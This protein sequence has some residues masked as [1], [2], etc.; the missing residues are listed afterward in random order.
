MI[1]MEPHKPSKIE[2]GRLRLISVFSLVDQVV[3]RMLFYPMVRTEISNFMDHPCKSGWSPLPAGYSTLQAVFSGPVLAT[4]CSAFDWTFP[5]WLVAPLLES[6]IEHMRG[7]SPKMRAAMERRW[8]EVI[9]TDCL[10]RLPDG[11][12]L[13]QANPGLMK[14][15]WLLTISV[16]SQ[17]QD[18]ITRVAWNRHR[19]DPFPPFWAMGDDVLMSWPDG[20][21][22]LLVAQ[23]RK[24]G[25]LTKIAQRSREFAGF[26]IPSSRAQVEPLYA[27]KHKFVLAH[28]PVE[29]LEEL[30]S[31]YALLYALSERRPLWLVEALQ[32]YS[33]YTQRACRAWATGVVKLRISQQQR[34][35]F[36]R[37]FG[38]WD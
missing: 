1:K 35:V 29:E 13:K 38:F 26:E 15:G 9:G 24:L 11:L 7:C 32:K 23:I 8:K 17:A 14:S 22:Q 27:D 28:T 18:L 2:E 37:Y 6:R 25:I 5:S 31:S 3:D 16:N 30:C 33:R 12:R 4:D 21:E 19:R 36:A 34:D 20:D 10:L